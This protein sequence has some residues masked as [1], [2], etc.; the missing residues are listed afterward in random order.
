M[1]LRTSLPVQPHLYI[2][3]STGRPLD[4][5]M[6]YFGQPNKDPEFYPIDIYYD[7]DLSLAA[8]QPVR[9]KGGF[10]NANGD[11][12]EIYASDYTYSVKVL[13]EHGV[14]VFY[15]P[16][17]ERVNISEDGKVST[18]LPYPQAITRTQAEK[19]AESITINDF[20]I[21]G[22][23]VTNET[24]KLA[25]IA[26]VVD[27]VDLLGKTV[28]SSVVPA[29]RFVN[30]V[31]KTSS[32]EYN[33]SL[34][35]PKKNG[36]RVATWNIWSGGSSTVN[37]GGDRYSPERFSQL[38][39]KLLQYG[40]DI[41][42]LQE[43]HHNTAVLPVTQYK[44]HPLV[45][46][47]ASVSMTYKNGDKYG[48]ITMATQP[49]TTSQS[50]VFAS[51]PSSSDSEFRSYVNTRYLYNGKIVSVYNTHFSLDTVRIESMAAELCNAVIGDGASVVFVM[52]DFNTNNWSLFSPLISA[53]FSQVNN[54]TIDTNPS[55]AT[56][57]IDDIF[58]KGASINGAPA[59]YIDTVLADHSA[60]YADFNI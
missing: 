30:G 47:V 51:P 54:N 6:V 36:V 7:K 37:F 4:Y 44:V 3:D 60:L 27:V 53:G 16:I 14:L 33:Y 20:G 17:I 41:V 45:S 58:Y 55:G 28:F 24:D 15:K 5:G 26:N 56:W 32:A 25:A 11:M 13:D 12:T 8:A 57:F 22:D 21:I 1:A 38:K 9:T 48:N 2:G 34:V 18:K 52:G 31:I 43:T 42:G 50:V 46:A 23:G 10:L 29:G 40:F 49:T 19:N 59:V 35:A 39:S